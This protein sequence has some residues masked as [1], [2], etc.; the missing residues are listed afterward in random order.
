M[1]AAWCWCEKARLLQRARLYIRHDRRAGAANDFEAGGVMSER[2]DTD[3]ARRYCQNA[4]IISK[5][6]SFSAP[7]HVAIA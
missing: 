7:W 1:W 6:H 3:G 2:E 5:R 4:A